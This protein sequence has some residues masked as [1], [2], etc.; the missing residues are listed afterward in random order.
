MV[1]CWGS[2]ITRHK[3][4]SG[5]ISVDQRWLGEGPDLVFTVA[6]I[7]GWHN[8]GLFSVEHQPKDSSVTPVLSHHPD[9]LLVSLTYFVP[10]CLSLSPPPHTHTGSL[11]S[12]ENLPTQT[13]EIF[14]GPPMCKQD[15]LTAI[16][17]C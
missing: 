11:H 15:S 4:Y 9:V 1:R 16:P 2:G 10:W 8:H 12:F 13:P 14:V 3:I 7:P 5:P 6:H 17:T